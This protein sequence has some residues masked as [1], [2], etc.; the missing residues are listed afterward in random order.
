LC[1]GNWDADWLAGK[2]IPQA[3][4]ILPLAL[5]RDNIAQYETDLVEPSPV[6]A[7]QTRRAQYLKMCV[8]IC[9]D[10]RNSYVHFPWSSFVRPVDRSRLDAADEHLTMLHPH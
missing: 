6:F 5:T 10:T 9:Y 3:I 1:L 4:D 2:S 7:D 8:N